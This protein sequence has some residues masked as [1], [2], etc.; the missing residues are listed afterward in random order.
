MYYVQ[1]EPNFGPSQAEPTLIC[2]MK[3]RAEIEFELNQA[4]SQAELM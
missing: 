3:H 2:L 4:E 1:M